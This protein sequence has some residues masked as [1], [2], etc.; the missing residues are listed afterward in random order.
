MTAEIAILM[1]LMLLKPFASSSNL[2]GRGQSK[3]C[4]QISLFNYWKKAQKTKTFLYL[5]PLQQRITSL[6]SA[7]EG[8]QI[9]SFRCEEIL[10]EEKKKTKETKLL[11]KKRGEEKHILIS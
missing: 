10:Q 3:T 11:G 7:T 4:E 5:F 8:R 1:I 6:S 9:S 2:K